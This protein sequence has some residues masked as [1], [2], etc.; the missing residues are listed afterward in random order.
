MCRCS[1][2]AEV[3]ETDGPNQIQR[4]NGRRRI[5]V[6]ANTD[7]SRHGAR[8]SPTSARDD[9]RDAS[10]RRA[11][12]PASKAQFQAQEEASRLIALLSLVSLAADLRRALQRYQSAV[13]ALIIMGNVPLALIGSVIALWIAGQPFSVASADRLHHA[14]RHRARATAS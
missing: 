14:R 12:S 5:V 7:G 10:C 8:S 4:E 2:V 1:A 13:L 3:V 11:T 6:L 9:R